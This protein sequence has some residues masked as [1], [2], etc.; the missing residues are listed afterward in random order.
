[1][2]TLIHINRECIDNL[3]LSPARI[4]IDKFLATETITQLPEIQFSILYEKELGD[5]REFSEIPEIRLWFIYLDT[6]YPFLPYLLDWRTELARYTAM[7][8]PH[9]FSPQDGLIYNPEALEI[10]VMNKLFTIFQWQKNRG[11]TNPEKLK[12]MALALGYEVDLALFS[13][14]KW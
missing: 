5:P 13:L 14:I 6:V 9:Q 11:Q 1:M 3:D 4:Y 12:M 10:F 8:V 7:L 2:P